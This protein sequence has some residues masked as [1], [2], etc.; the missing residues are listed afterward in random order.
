MAL[1]LHYF[2]RVLTLINLVRACDQREPER[3]KEMDKNKG[4]FSDSGHISGRSRAFAASAN[5][6]PAIGVNS[7]SSG[8]IVSLWDDW[9]R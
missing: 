7:R 1:T 5:K 6:V 2:M 3:L 4:L 8:P 9:V